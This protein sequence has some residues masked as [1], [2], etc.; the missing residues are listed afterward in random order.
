MANVDDK[1]TNKGVH[2]NVMDVE[3]VRSAAQD[4]GAKI[5]DGAQQVIPNQ[6]FVSS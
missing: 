4:I 2:D 1:D 6:S 3:D 5:I